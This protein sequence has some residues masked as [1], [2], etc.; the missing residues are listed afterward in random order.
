MGEVMTFGEKRN[1]PGGQSSGRWKKPQDQEKEQEF[2]NSNK[3]KKKKVITSGI[4]RQKVLQI[5]TCRA[6]PTDVS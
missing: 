2:K 6:R 3:K 5:G 4:E 1:P